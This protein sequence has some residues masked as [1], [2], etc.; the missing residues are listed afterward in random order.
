MSEYDHPGSGAVIDAVEPPPP[1]TLL[2][3]PP[4]GLERV[5]GDLWK[6]TRKL[7]I[8]GV[9]LVAPLLL[10]IA[11]QPGVGGSGV[12]RDAFWVLI[13]TSLAGLGVLIEAFIDAFRLLRR[14]AAA[15]DTGYGWRLI[16]LVA[17]DDVR[18]SGFLVQGARIYGDMSPAE[19]SGLRAIR[20]LSVLLY[21]SAAL[22]LIA[23]FSIGVLLAARG[24]LFASALVWFILLPTILLAA[25]GF[26]ADSWQKLVVRRARR[27]WY[28]QPWAA[29]LAS[30]DVRDWQERA[31]A[32]ADPAVATRATGRSTGFRI[33]AALVIVLGVLVSLPVWPL[34][35]TAGVGPVLAMI[36]TPRFAATQQRV[37][38]VEPLRRYRPAV[39]SSITPLEA[40]EILHALQAMGP[41]GPRHPLMRA[42]VR[43]YERSWQSEGQGPDNP[44]GHMIERWASDVLPVRDELN[45]QARAYIAEVAS[46][47]A[48]ADF[49]R[50]ARA[51]AIDLLGARYVEI[52]DTLAPWAL[53]MPRFGP[54]RMAGHAHVG[55]AI[56]Q[57]QQG[58]AA[59]AEETIR[60]V[61]G[62]GFLLVDE[63]QTLLEN[64]IGLV[65]VD[66]GGDALERFYRATGRVDEADDLAWARDAASR[67]GERVRALNHWEASSALTHYRGMPAVVL[68]TAAL[69]GLRWEYLMVINTVGPCL[70]L[71][72]TVFGPDRA[73]EEW[74]RQARESLVRYPSEER[75][76][77]LTRGGFYGSGGPPGERRW[78]ARLLT[79]AM[80]GQG[81]PGSCASLVDAIDGS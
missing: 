44:T 8:G 15:V 19:R 43:T 20:V 2:P 21:A 68:D 41:E 28:R 50:L 3:W 4:P 36:S 9:I 51:G 77:E 54:V 26:L 46:H 76:F 66:I 14:F 23:G 61:I 64:L 58:R 69:D 7:F 33:A 29:Q 47:P 74:I 32:S 78:P 17:A 40:G 35:T 55:R 56:Y 53:P 62:A 79:F 70:N 1:P 11:Y 65:L 48:H 27:A 5:Q 81:T 52:P 60:N 18:D 57:L 13:L 80:G 75:L 31:D 71:N 73:Y 6:V 34:V 38:T 25:I 72:R 10:A 67:A 16:A 39:D 24:A 42:P 37:A 30:G 49:A 63:G 12:F 22:W 59:E 45:A